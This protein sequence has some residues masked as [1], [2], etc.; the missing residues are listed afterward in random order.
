MPPFPGMNIPSAAGTHKFPSLTRVNEPALRR[1]WHCLCRGVLVAVAACSLAHTARA[2]IYRD[3]ETDATSLALAQ[4]PQFNGA[5][6]VGV[7]NTGYGPNGSGVAI[8]PDWVLTAAHLFEGTSSSVV[9]AFYL[10]GVEY[11]GPVYLDNTDTSNPSSDLALINLTG[12]AGSSAPFT[13]L[14]SSIN[15]IQ[16]NIPA[17][18]LSPV[19]QV[20]WTAGYGGAANYS[21]QN[22]PL[23]YNTG[24][25]AGTNVIQNFNSN[26][27][28]GANNQNTA[29]DATAFESSTA[30]GDSGGPMYQQ[31]GNRWYVSGVTFG[32]GDFTPTNIA[33]QPGAENTEE[34][35]NFIANT[36]AGY[37]TATSAV[38]YSM[39][40]KPVA[41][42][43]N[44]TAGS[45]TWD[46]TQT[47]FTDGTLQ[48]QW[49]NTLVEDVTFGSSTI[50]SGIVTVVPTYLK[51]GAIT[52][53]GVT[54]HDMTFNEP[55]DGGT[56]NITAGRLPSGSAGGT[57]LGTITFTTSSNSAGNPTITTNY[58]A[59]ISAPIVTASDSTLVKGGPGTLALSGDNTGFAGILQIVAG[60]VDAQNANALGSGGFSDADSTYV[61]AGGTLK[62]DGG[63]SSDEHIHLNGTGAGGNGALYIAGGANTL[64]D[65]V[66]FDTNATVNVASGAS[67][68]TTGNFGY[69]GNVITLTGGGTFNLNGGSNNVS[70][71]VITGSTLVEQ[72]SGGLVNAAVTLNVSGGA[73]ALNANTQTF[74][75]VTLIGG[76][77][78]LALNTVVPGAL[79]NGLIT[80]TGRLTLGQGIN[81]N[82]LPGSSFGPGTYILIDYTS[83]TDNSD[84]FSGWSVT[85]LP[86]GTA[87]SFAFG[88]DAL[89]L[90]VTGVPEPSS[91][92]WCMACAGGWLAAR[93]RMIRRGAA[94][95]TR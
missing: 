3:D 61:L 60:T 14:P 65:P 92:L 55:S 94:S 2:I 49:D 27:F 21:T 73:Y 88:V 74:A 28:W 25:R 67:L 48:Y 4:Q 70:G 7:A 89:E 47:N 39:T 29:P 30:P 63:Y 56:Y 95:K 75:S 81:F 17:D 11:T 66:S 38:S 16:A 42:V 68:T 72:D 90:V 82:A 33:G 18:N 77:F 9:G 15:I 83:L 85:G 24:V 46:L 34:T 78:Q 50:P 64:T 53:A 58:N 44:N 41:G 40:W 54:V 32:P 23:S 6:Q 62:I 22:G 57:A 13:G 76:G 80:A 84:N 52:A 43:G 79:G 91:Y 69:S 71:V 87:G 12:I 8:A 51:G 10:D 59:T 86:A 37:T 1:R 31:Y 20:I 45:S 26:A 19:N 36:I 5:G 35:N 93:R